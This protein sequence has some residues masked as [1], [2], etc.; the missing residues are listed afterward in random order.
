VAIKLPGSI[1]HIRKKRYFASEE[2][3]AHK[4]EIAS[5]VPEYNEVAEYTAE[6][7]ERAGR[8]GWGSRPRVPSRTW[9][10]S[11]TRATKT[12]AETETWRTTAGGE[13]MAGFLAAT[14]HGAPVADALQV[15]ADQARV[16]IEANI[17]ARCQLLG[18]QGLESRPPDG[19]WPLL[20][21]NHRV[22]HIPECG[23]YGQPAVRQCLANGNQ[24]LR[25]RI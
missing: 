9:R 18:Q 10:H 6:I 4:A 8:S 19:R 7:R 24:I 13:F 1:R 20:P 25:V 22:I 16:A 12:T 21:N 23:S 11:K 14:L 5:V 3:L 2:F 17:C 15:A